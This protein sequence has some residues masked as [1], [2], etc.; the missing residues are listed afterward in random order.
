LRIDPIKGKIAI[1]V[2][3]LGCPFSGHPFPTPPPILNLL[4]ASIAFLG[5][6]KMGVSWCTYEVD[7]V[8]HGLSRSIDTFNH[9]K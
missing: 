2:D 6:A 9:V 3:S 4:N 5:N 7:N 8:L 1:S